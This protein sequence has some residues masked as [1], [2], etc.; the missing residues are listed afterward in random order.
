MNQQ[1]R[2]FLR[3]ISPS[4]PAWKPPPIWRSGRRPTPA[5]KR[6]LPEPPRPRWPSRK[7]HSDAAAFRQLQDL[8]APCGRADAGRIASAA[9]G[10]TGVPP[11][12]VAGRTAGTD[13][14][15]SKDIERMF[16][17]FRGELD[18]Q[19]LSNNELLGRLRK[20]TRLAR[21]QQTWEA[22]KQVGGAVAPELIALAE[23]PQRRPPGSWAS[24]TSGTWRSGCRNT[25]PRSCWPSSTNWNT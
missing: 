21:R 6:I 7:Y 18:G 4:S 20:Q 22:L 1:A 17:T 2:D 10:G 12:P 9:T 25:T 14:Q 8:I 23:A 13:G 15:L 3:L 19:S 11:E 24:P 5:G 16:S